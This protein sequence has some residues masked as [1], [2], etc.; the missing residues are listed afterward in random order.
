MIRVRARVRARVRDIFTAWNI[1]VSG[2]A[3]DT[4]LEG[5]GLLRLGLGLGLRIRWV[6]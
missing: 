1:V 4:W 3:E 2:Y 5:S 6:S